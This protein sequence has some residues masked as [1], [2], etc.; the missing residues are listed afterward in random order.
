MN[1]QTAARRPLHGGSHRRIVRRL[2]ALALLR[3]AVPGAGVAAQQTT[4]M[5][6]PAVLARLQGTWEGE[7]TLLERPATYRMRWETLA[8]GFYRLDF[9]NAWVDGDGNTTP[10]LAAHAVYLWRGPSAVGVWLD[11][12][13]QRITMEAFA[14]DSSVVAR[15]TAEAEEGRTEYRLTAAGTVEVT[16]FVHVEGVERVFG[17]ATYRR[18]AGGEMP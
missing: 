13:P 10:V 9:G 3:A 6:T 5:E 17:R 12:R 15:W 14:T 1:G 7:G 8:A 4:P 18:V 11:D 2:A 16:D